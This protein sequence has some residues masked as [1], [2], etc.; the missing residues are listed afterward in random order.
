[1]SENMTLPQYVE[2]QITAKC[3]LGCIHCQPLRRDP[4]FDLSTPAATALV[5]ELLDAHVKSITL[6]GGEPL[7]RDDWELIA[8]ILKE[9]SV[10]VQII[11]N[12]QLVDEDVARR[13]ARLGVNFVWLS[14]DGPEQAHN[15]IRRHPKA[16]ER[17]MR[18]SEWLEKMEVPYGFM[19]TL[20]ATNFDQLPELSEIVQDTSAA[21]WQIWLGNQI[22]NAPIW[23]KPAQISPIIALLPRLRTRTPQLIIGDNIGYSDAIEKLRTPGFMPYASTSR[24]SGCYGADTIMGIRNDGSIKG[25]LSMPEAPATSLP[26]PP[27]PLWDRF[28]EARRLHL[29]LMEKARSQCSGCANLPKCNGGCP[30]WALTCNADAKTKF[31][32]VMTSHPPLRNAAITASLATLC[33]ISAPLSPVSPLPGDASTLSAG[34]AGIYRVRGDHSTAD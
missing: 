19:T 29:Q 15:T 12:G 11:S 16:F 20:L 18:A 2:W 17:V 34:D 24:F 23:L 31:C 13:I 32:K 30:A 22:S 28:R 1:M 21:L 6:T 3:N 27:A 14:L 25:C 8:G 7:L 33:A 4:R 9:N 10:S 5:H 26:S